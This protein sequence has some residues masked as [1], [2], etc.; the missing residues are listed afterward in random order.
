[1]SEK[2]MVLKLLDTVP[3]NKLGCVIAYLQGITADEAE[4]DAFCELLLKQY[5]DDPEKGQYIT[6][7]EMAKTCGVDIN[8]I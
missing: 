8:A 3:Q 7:E 1:M 6:I 4:D 2:E 5:E